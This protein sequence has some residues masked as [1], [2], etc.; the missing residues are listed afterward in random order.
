M[1]KITLIVTAFLFAIC[2]TMP[3]TSLAQDGSLDLTF[4]FDGIVNTPVGNGAFANSLAIQSDGKIVAAGYAHII[5]TRDFALVRYNTNGSLD[6]TF[7]SDG[8]VTTPI[9]MTSDDEAY[10]IAIQSDGKIV[11][12]GTNET[13]FALVRYNTNGTL[14]ISFGNGGIVTTQVA[15]GNEYIASI[16]IQSD[17]KI[18][19][20]GW[21]SSGVSPFMI[22]RYNTNGSLD[23]TF[24]NDGIVITTI[25]L[26]AKAL[27]VAIQN[28]G[29][30][31]VAGGS[32]NGFISHNTLARYNTNGSLDNTFDTDG[33][34]VTPVGLGYSQ[35]NSIAIQSDGKIV[36]AGECLYSA[37]DFGLIRYNINGSLD[38]TFDT[39]GIVVTPVV[40]PLSEDFAYSVNIQSDG[41]IVTTGTAYNNTAFALARYN[42]NGSLD[43]T[44]DSAGIVITP[45]GLNTYASSIAIQSNGKIVV[46]GSNQNDF[47]LVRY[48]NNIAIEINEIANQNTEIK[49]FPNPFSTLT[50]L[51]SENT[52]KDATLTVCNL[53][54]QEVKSLKNLSGQ[55]I[56]LNRDN[57]P[58]GLYFIQLTENNKTISVEKLVITD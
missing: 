42:T 39:D 30:I 58:Q 44:F 7:D 20:V 2:F 12:A 40:V 54:G 13:E 45:M 56:I 21:D 17:G 55:T 24:D 14:D 18:V 32:S 27:S 51:Q 48:N 47:T 43:N 5:S 49:I 52:F 11:V 36:A 53:Y 57:L 50:T 1:K 38:S 22:V 34:V 4:D 15:N 6:N 23:N 37:H 46:A 19:A 35:A 25:G 9:G 33:I 31:V 29:K 3:V 10:S 26:G 41:K 28:D 8:I 16:A